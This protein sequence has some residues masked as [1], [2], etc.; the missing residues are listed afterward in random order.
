MHI[1]QSVT[2]DGIIT[3]YEMGHVDKTAFWAALLTDFN[4]EV[5]DFVREHENT[6][7]PA[8]SDVL[9]TEHYIDECDGEGMWVDVGLEHSCEL[10]G[11]ECGGLTDKTQIKRI[12]QVC[13]EGLFDLE[14]AAT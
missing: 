9:H 6:H 11:D 12:T 8:L 3:W 7:L 10:N 5:T 2:D 14:P 1:Q 4:D 13:S